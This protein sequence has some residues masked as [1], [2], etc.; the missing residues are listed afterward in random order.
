MIISSVTFT[1]SCFDNVN[2]S[3]AS[4]QPGSVTTQEMQSCTE[5]FSKTSLTQK[6]KHFFILILPKSFV[7]QTHTFDMVITRRYL[8]TH[9][10]YSNAIV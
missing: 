4:H 8:N 7:K 3:V 2:N 10:L 9:I 6:L 1:E 5:E